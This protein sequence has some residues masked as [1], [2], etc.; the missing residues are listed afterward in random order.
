MKF[1]INETGSNIL[2]I[3]AGI[4]LGVLI[5]NLLFEQPSVGIIRIEG[6]VLEDQKTLDLISMLRYARET[7]SI[8]AVVLAIDSPGGEASRCEEV[9]LEVL[10]LRREKPVIASIGTT[11]A[12]GA[13]YIAVA[14]N[15]IYAKPTSSVGSV[16]VTAI[17][18]QPITLPE[19]R[20]VTGPFKTTGKDRKQ[21]AATVEAVKES[22]LRAVIQQRGDRLKLTKEE[23]SRGELYIGI[24]AK[25]YGLVDEIGSISQAIA[26]AASLAGIVNYKTIDIN[27]ELNITSTNFPLLVNESYLNQQSNTAPVAYFLYIEPGE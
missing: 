27:K 9:Y 3:V 13:Y 6:S 1:K 7:N 20:I 16:G 24:D 19:D 17:L 5:F 11:G 21:F 10:Q 4:F 15:Y 25:R 23:L 26:K 14:S 12:S 22:F 18:P 8:K 2:V